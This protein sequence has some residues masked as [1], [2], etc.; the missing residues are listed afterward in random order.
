M[1]SARSKRLLILR[2]TPKDFWGEKSKR[3]T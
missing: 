3:Y 2:I 1:R